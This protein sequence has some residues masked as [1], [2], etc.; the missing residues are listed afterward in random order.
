MESWLEIFDTLKKN[1]LRTCLTGFSVTWGIL[2]LIILVSFGSGLKQFATGMFSNDMANTMY[3]SGKNTSKPFKGSLPGKKIQFG[4]KDIKAIIDQVED[5]EYYS[6]RVNITPNTVLHK[7]KKGSFTIRSVH[8]IHIAIEANTLLSGRFINQAD[9]K[10]FRKVAV[11]GIT[12]QDMLFEK[13]VDPIGAY[14]E[15]NKIPFKVVGVQMDESETDENSMIYLPVTTAQ[16]TFGKAESVDQIVVT[17]KD[18]SLIQGMRT[19]KKIRTVLGQ[20]NNFDPSDNRALRI[21]NKLKSTEKVFTMLNSIQLFTIF[22]GFL[23]IVSGSIGVMNIMVI[24]VKERT[25]EIGLRRAVGA[26]PSAII[27]SIIK[28]SVLLTVFFG[29]LGLLIAALV[30]SVV[31]AFGQNEAFSN[32]MV[33]IPI[34]LMATGILVL[35]GLIAGLVPAIKAIKIR[36][37]EALNSN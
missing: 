22:I 23:A 35:V 30:L 12:V 33:N 34:A 14:I 10:D 6:A 36:P 2:I 27:S 28:E 5:V 21:H 19:E 3:I 26:S 20:V 1:K 25:N 11:I 9:L 29:Y 17:I 7:N 31:N 8:P 4:N 15:I 18:P 13:G 24:S 16:K 32:L 37:V